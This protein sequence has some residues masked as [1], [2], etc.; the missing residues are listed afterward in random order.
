MNENRPDPASELRR[1]LDRL[2]D[3]EL[4]E[5]E[6]S[7]LLARLDGIQDGWKLCARALLE[8]QA[9]REAFGEATPAAF[10]SMRGAPKGRSQRTAWL[11]IAAAACLAF[12]AGKFAGGFAS[13]DHQRLANMAPV[14]ELPAT[15]TAG[16]R[17]VG[18]FSWANAGPVRVAGVPEL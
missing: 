18:Q 12:V 5:R 7:E 15:T 13:S 4:A 14:A 11:A 9:F 3:G 8:A 16:V 6:R 10:T 17:T 1:S 2:A